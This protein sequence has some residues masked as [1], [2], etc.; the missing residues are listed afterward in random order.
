MVICNILR[1]YIHAVRPFHYIVRVKK[2]SI[3]IIDRADVTESGYLQITLNIPIWV[4]Q[5]Y[6]KTS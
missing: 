5:G 4:L 6:H 2:K 1:Q 3:I